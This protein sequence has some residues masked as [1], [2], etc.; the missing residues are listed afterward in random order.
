MARTPGQPRGPIG[1]PGRGLRSR[2]VEVSCLPR[3]PAAGRSRFALRSLS[4]VECRIAGRFLPFAGRAGRQ[5]GRQTLK[6]SHDELPAD[7]GQPSGRALQS[8]QEL[9]VPSAQAA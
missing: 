4:S 1:Q 8:Q 2:R 3:L 7:V 9:G 6:H 5:A